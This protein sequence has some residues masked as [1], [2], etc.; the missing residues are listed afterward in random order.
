MWYVRFM[1]CQYLT[2]IESVYRVSQRTVRRWCEDGRILGAYR[3]SPRKQ[4]R[5]RKPADLDAWQKA[6]IES[7]GEPPQIKKEYNTPGA[8]YRMKFETRGDIR[9]WT[10]SQRASFGNAM[11]DALVTLVRLNLL[12]PIQHDPTKDNPTTRDGY[13]LGLAFKS[14]KDRNQYG[15]EG[16]ETNLVRALKD[17]GIA[18]PSGIRVN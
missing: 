17:H 14:G 1:A 13:R 7:L 16:F 9:R 5:V 15:N 2:T 8:G 18:V 10:Q 6:V 3:P 11:I 12:E 4:W